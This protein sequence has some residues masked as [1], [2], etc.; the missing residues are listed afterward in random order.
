M[1]KFTCRNSNDSIFYILFILYPSIAICNV[2]K[3][4]YNT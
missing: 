4:L 1:N 3:C 2:V